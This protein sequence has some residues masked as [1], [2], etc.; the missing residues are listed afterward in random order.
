MRQ[1]FPAA[2]ILGALLVNGAVFA[3]AGLQ[4]IPL[5]WKPTSSFSQMGTIDLSG[6]TIATKIHFDPLV[7][8]RQNPTL[9]AENRE[10]AEVRQV[11]TSSE[12][13][14]FVTD[15]LKDTMRSAGLSVVD[16]AADVTVSGEIR[17]FFV[18][19]DSTYNGEISLM[20]HVKDAAGKE[21][22]AGVINGDATRFGR[23]YKAEN[24]FEVMS[25]M[26]LRATYNLLATDGFRAALTK[27]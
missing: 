12:V 3:A 6:G 7:D 26:L 21:L 1:H 9:V 11:T 8:T 18:A 5:Q 17:K 22:W 19:E 13:A 20:I 14:A 16:A 24:Y 4:N 27:H 23:S 25:D 15:H 2:A 10:K